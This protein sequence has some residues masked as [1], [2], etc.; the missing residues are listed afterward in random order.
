ME[1]TPLTTKSCLNCEDP[2]LPEYHLA[3]Y[4][5]SNAASLSLIDMQVMHSKR[6]HKYIVKAVELISQELKDLKDK[7]KELESKLPS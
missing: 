7:V 5:D 3:H 4:I 6:A 1:D 2:A